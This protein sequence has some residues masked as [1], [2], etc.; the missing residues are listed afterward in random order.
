M[1]KIILKSSNA[2]LAAIL[3]LFGIAGCSGDEETLYGVPNG[4]FGSGAY[5]CPPNGFV[6]NGN[7][8]NENGEPINNIQV[9][10]PE[11]DTSYTYGQGY[12]YL[13]SH[14]NPGAQV[15]LYFNDT[16]GPANGSYQNDSTD[17]QIEDYGNGTG[18]GYASKTLK[19]KTE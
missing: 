3:A 17:V 5:G 13:K 8:T 10:W 7:V 19:E 9:V 18:R 1:K 12:F 6:I 16:D 11:K 4:E 14:D 2:L 15:R